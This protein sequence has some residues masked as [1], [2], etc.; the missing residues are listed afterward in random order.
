MIELLP[1]I[2]LYA[3]ARLALSPISFSNGGALNTRGARS[4]LLTALMTQSEDRMH[5]FNMMTAVGTACLDTSC[6]RPERLKINQAAFELHLRKA[7]PSQ[8][9]QADAERPLTLSRPAESAHPPWRLRSRMRNSSS[10]NFDPQHTQNAWSAALES[11]VD[12]FRRCLDGG[13]GGKETF[14]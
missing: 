3:G 12:R 1:H 7:A 5:P 4:P 9:R 11:V 13:L 14:H 10:S 2:E 6:V 8:T